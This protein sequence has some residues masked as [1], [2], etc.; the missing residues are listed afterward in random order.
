MQGRAIV[1]I[2]PTQKGGWLGQTLSSGEG[3]GAE[4][5]SEFRRCLNGRY[6]AFLQGG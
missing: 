4:Y 3:V 2:D 5:S 6:G 1:I